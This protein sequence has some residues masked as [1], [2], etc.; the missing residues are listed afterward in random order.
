MCKPES[1]FSNA[2]I[3]RVT[4]SLSESQ[5]KHKNSLTIFRPF[6]VCWFLF[7]QKITLTSSSK[8]SS[9]LADGC[10]C[11]LTWLSGRLPTFSLTATDD[12]WYSW[13][14][15]CWFLFG[16]AVTCIL[17][18]IDFHIFS[19]SLTLTQWNEENRFSTNVNRLSG[20]KKKACV[21]CIFFLVV[22][23]AAVDL[24]LCFCLLFNFR[25]YLYVFQLNVTD[26]LRLSFFSRLPP[27][28]RVVSMYPLHTE[29]TLS[30]SYSALFAF[31]TTR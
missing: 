24:L 27:H 4:L 7:T 17:W 13:C 9:A 5:P 22:S 10:W 1:G 21:V 3:C 30:T 23:P 14:C 16:C 2:G 26:S 25:I 12:W 28:T 11:P 6:L 29:I 20:E 15:C 31:T 19:C 18:L 8:F